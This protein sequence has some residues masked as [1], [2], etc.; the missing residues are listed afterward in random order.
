MD[1]SFVADLIH[2]I[3]YYSGHKRSRGDHQ[4]NGRR[5]LNNRGHVPIYLNEFPINKTL[6][7]GSIVPLLPAPFIVTAASSAR[8]P[9]LFLFYARIPYARSALDHSGRSLV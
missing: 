6:A 3:Q 8:R 2:N 7:C 1:T 4:T 5:H 9:S